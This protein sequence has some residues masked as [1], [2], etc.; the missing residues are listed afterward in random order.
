MNSTISGKETEYEEMKKE[1]DQLVLA[2]QRFYDQAT[3]FREMYV[4]LEGLQ[5]RK[6]RYQED[7]DNAKENLQAVDGMPNSNSSKIKETHSHAW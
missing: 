4:K 2:N 7:L 3:K 5:E 1:Y 6:I